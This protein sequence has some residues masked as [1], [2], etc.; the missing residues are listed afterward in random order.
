MSGIGS[1]ALTAVLTRG[2]RSLRLDGDS[3]HRQE[4]SITL[5]GHSPATPENLVMVGYRNGVL[6]ATVASFAGTSSS[7]T[8]TLDTNTEEM[9]DAFEDISAGAIQNIDLRLWDQSSQELIG[10]GV[11]ELRSTGFTY[12]DDTGA[13]PV[14]PVS[15]TTII[16]GKLALYSGKTYLKNDEDGLW[17]PFSL[18][19]SGET[20]H[21]EYDET[22][23]IT[24]TP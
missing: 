14:T 6:V 15:G 20:I 7:A 1:S 11:L 10:L 8:G 23:G 24:I 19:G 5:T 22:G 18:K 9:E 12:S 13:T 2:A 21:E 4:L 17:Y 3:W 16:W